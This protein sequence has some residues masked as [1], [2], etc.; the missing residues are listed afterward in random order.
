MELHDGVPFDRLGSMGAAAVVRPVGTI[1]ATGITNTT[2]RITL[3]SV[4][5][6]M[7]RVTRSLGE[8]LICPWVLPCV[9]GSPAG[10]QTFLNEPLPRDHGRAGVSPQKGSL[11]GAVIGTR[12]ITSDKLADTLITRLTD[13]T[14]LGDT[15]MFHS[16][17]AGQ[18][19]GMHDQNVLDLGFGAFSPAASTPALT[20]FAFGLVRATTEV[21]PRRWPPR[22]DQRQTRLTGAALHRQGLGLRAGLRRERRG[23]APTRTADW[24]TPRSVGAN[25]LIADATA[26]SSVASSDLLL[27]SK[28]AAQKRATVARLQAAIGSG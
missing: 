18:P 7:E 24:S 17:A 11:G 9:G 1:V 27:I 22:S 19:Q 15:L 26:A 16:A 14:P 21:H 12:S 6:D 25:T 4:N 23:P 10:R 2:G 8:S 20:D 13:A 3:R 28:A 5:L